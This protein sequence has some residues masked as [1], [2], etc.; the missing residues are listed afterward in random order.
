M[1]G[2][3]LCAWGLHEQHVSQSR[4]PPGEKVT[5]GGGAI[6]QHIS[7]N[8]QHTEQTW[9]PALY[10][11]FFITMGPWAPGKGTGKC[12][13]RS[14]IGADSLEAAQ[15]WI[16]ACFLTGRTLRLRGEIQRKRQLSILEIC[17]SHWAIYPEYHTGKM[18]FHSSAMHANRLWLEA[19]VERDTADTRRHSSCWLTREN[20]ELR[21]LCPQTLFSYLCVIS[22]G[23]LPR[24]SL[25][26]L[27]SLGWRVYRSGS[28]R[29][30][31]TE[32]ARFT[33]RQVPYLRPGVSSYWFFRGHFIII[34]LKTHQT[35]TLKP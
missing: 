10:Q 35:S 27:P 14:V 24:P 21:P 28:L 9:Q 18:S 29:W 1:E 7:P 2:S 34:L 25:C 12:T 32:E 19:D 3:G 33:T 20:A 13:D 5:A 4:F 6:K 17:I 22:L 15:H 16:T 8:A 23:L 11:P 30:S 31:L 26:L